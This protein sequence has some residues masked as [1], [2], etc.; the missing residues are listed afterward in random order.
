MIHV[1]YA[2]VG[3]GV[4]KEPK[5]RVSV[6][7]CHIVAHLYSMSSHQFFLE[8]SHNEKYIVEHNHLKESLP[9]GVK[10]SNEK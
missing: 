5:L 3:K 10:A 9:D 8:S 2:W 1:A 4:G 7:L 6:T